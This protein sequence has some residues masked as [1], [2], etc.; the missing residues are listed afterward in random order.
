MHEQ[1]ITLDLSSAT[2]KQIDAIKRKAKRDGVTFEE[3]AKR[4]LLQLADREERKGTTGPIA[5]LF[6]FP[7]VH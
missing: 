6:R 5:R 1:A 2:D 3:A 4:L 7:S